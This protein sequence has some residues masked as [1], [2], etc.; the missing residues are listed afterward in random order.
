[1]ITAW[2]LTLRAR[3]ERKAAL[4]ENTEREQDIVP[5]MTVNK[6]G[7]RSLPKRWHW[8]PFF[9]LDKTDVSDPSLASQCTERRQCVAWLLKSLKA[10]ALCVPMCLSFLSWLKTSVHT[11]AST[12]SV[13][14]EFLPTGNAKRGINTLACTLGPT[15]NTNTNQPGWRLGPW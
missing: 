9:S 10:S 2:S 6:Q 13:S 5:A 15:N 8:P 11:S 12:I 3:V 1:M 4:N 7:R 14:K